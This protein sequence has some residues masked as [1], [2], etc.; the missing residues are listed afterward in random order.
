MRALRGEDVHDVEVAVQTDH[1]RRT[2]SVDGGPVAAPPGGR[3]GALVVM[4][5]VTAR[6]AREDHWRA[7]GYTVEALPSAVAL[8]GAADGRFVWVNP[9]WERM[10]GYGRDDILGSHVS[11]VNAAGELTPQDRGA[12]ILGALDHDGLWR[13]ELEHVR[14]DGTHFWSAAEISRC[15]H[16]QHGLVWLAVHTDVTDQKTADRELRDAAERYWRIFEQAPIGMALVG[17]DLRILDV[18]A[19]L[20]RLVGHEQSEL[21]N[22]PL[23]DIAHPDDRELDVQL[24]A[25]LLHGEIP[26]YRLEERYVTADGVTVPVG[27]TVTL[28]RSGLGEPLFALV[29]AYGR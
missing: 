7:Q 15:D 19:A 2:F 10:F 27:L 26:E 8:T 16:P 3:S 17:R 11:L 21:V 18:N 1:G 13:G 29:L 14:R 12:D 20:C 28:V 24:V 5:D 6:L 23:A 22:R 4:S 9:S 25:R